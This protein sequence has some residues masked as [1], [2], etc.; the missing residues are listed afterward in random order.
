MVIVV[1]VEVD[2]RPKMSNGVSSVIAQSRVISEQQQQFSLSWPLSLTNNVL[3]NNFN[4]QQYHHEQQYGTSDRLLSSKEVIKERRA[5]SPFNIEQLNCLCHVILTTHLDNVIDTTQ[6][7]SQNSKNRTVKPPNNLMTDA[8][9]PAT[10]S[11]IKDNQNDN[12]DAHDN[13]SNILKDD[14]IIDNYHIDYSN[15]DTDSDTDYDEI[16]IGARRLNYLTCVRKLTRL[17]SADLLPELSDLS[18]E[19]NSENSND[20]L[21]V[22]HCHM[23]MRAKAHVYF[24]RASYKQLYQLLNK[25][26]IMFPS[27]YHQ[28]LQYLWFEAHYRDSENARGRKLGAVDK[29]RLRKRHK[30]PKS[31]W[32]GEETVYCFKEK[33]R[34][35]LKLCYQQNKYPSQEDKLKLSKLTG[36]TM[37]QIGNWFKNRRQ[38]DHQQQSLAYP[39]LTSNYA[40]NDVDNSQTRVCLSRDNHY[41]HL[42]TQGHTQIDYGSSVIPK[43]QYYCTSN[44]PAQFDN[45]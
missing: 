42:D 12:H 21:T 4:N 17:L 37:T 36:L 45:W 44:Q 22:D 11:T 15:T 8:T 26:N 16:V 13:N 27:K 24:H 43:K 34:S 40:N 39:S 31:I 14:L 10:T 19:E 28:E 5:S 25:S 23:L 32:D 35:T 41:L 9:T 18:E 33:S 7:T 6:I 20:N 38:R 30:L 2:S 29:Y 3:P 1:I